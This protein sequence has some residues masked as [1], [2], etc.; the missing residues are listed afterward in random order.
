MGARAAGQRLHPPALPPSP[1]LL[2]CAGQAAG[3]HA[4]SCKGVLQANS[5]S[6][7][8][9]LHLSWLLQP[10]LIML[11]TGEV[12][13]QLQLWQLFGCTSTSSRG[14]QALNAGV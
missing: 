13:W 3:A 8:G 12:G 9:L 14:C 6:S 7:S 11:H 10:L 5:S 4:V 1:P 2:S